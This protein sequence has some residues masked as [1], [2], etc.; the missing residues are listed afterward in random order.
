MCLFRGARVHCYEPNPGNFKLLMRNTQSYWLYTKLYELALWKKGVQQVSMM[1]M[2]GYTA[3]HYVDCAGEDG[4]TFPANS[5][6]LDSIIRDAGQEIRLL[7]LDCEGG[8]WPGLYESND[9]RRVKEI[10]AELH[11]NP[12]VPGFDCTTE[13]MTAHLESRGFDVKQAPSRL[14]GNERCTYLRATRRD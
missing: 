10:I 14:P 8:E 4:K 7:K 12:P 2:R 9:I 6:D 5:T 13:A 1:D 11:T 3:C